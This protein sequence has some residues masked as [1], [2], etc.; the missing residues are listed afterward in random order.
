MF[1]TVRNNKKI[2]QLVLAII[3]LPFALWGVDSYV[4]NS[5]GADIAT[6]GDT[7][8]APE[9]FQRAL[10]EQQDRLRPQVGTNTAILESPEFRNGVLQELIN[11]RLLLLY[12]AKSQMKVSNETLSGFISSLPSLQVNGKF[13][14]E[15]YEA[16]VAAQQMSVAQFE[17]MLKQDLLMQQ[18]TLAVGNAAVSGRLPAD[19]WL[20]AQLEEREIGEAV[21]RA[22]QFAGDSKPDAD[23]VKRFYEENRVRFEQPEQVRVEYLVLNQSKAIENAKIS[24]GDIKAWYQ[25]NEARYKK[26]EQRRASHILIRADKNAPAAEVKAAE[27]KAHQI[28]AQLKANPA[29]FAKLAKDHSQDPG[30]A[31]NGGDLGY[32]GRGM[33]VKPFEEATYSL[34]ENQL[35]EVVRSDFGFHLIKLTG[36]RSEQAQPLDEVRG[37]ILAELKRQAGTKRYVEAAEGFSNTVYEQADSL[38]PAAEKYGLSIQS[39]EWLAK[40]GQ[41]MPP[42]THPKLV[43]ALFS[44]DAV[45]NKRNTEAIEAAPNTL[46]SARV[47]EYRPATVEPLEKVAG[48]I[49]KVLAREVALT[50]AAA[51]GQTELD[52]LNK[53]E[54]VNLAWAKARTVSRLHAP[55][56]S[57]E[58]LAAVFSADTHKLPSYTGVKTTGGFALYRIDKVKAFDPA[59]ENEAAARAQ[60]LRQKYSEILAQE[61]MVNW[62]STLRQHYGVKIN[63]A[64]LERK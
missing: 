22:E 44:D 51:A 21:L 39:S 6:V 56:L 35:S 31:A 1:D 40:G 46:V 30:S 18:T 28:L 23:A 20:A 62:L 48:M 4:R 41:L 8:I 10:S 42:F 59:A 61:D 29:D 60:A 15:Q 14:R 24:E 53:G 32:F 27:E 47:V 52:K 25:A 26:S 33:M 50:K 11:R 64:A 19:R 57:P 45:K 43:A 16:L 55:N 2:V 7:P 38:Q 36:V 37:E 49:E 9:E 54:K 17:A 12:A 63:S 34:K 58:A 5:R 3:I 13:S